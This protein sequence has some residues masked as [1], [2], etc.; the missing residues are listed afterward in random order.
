M[1]IAPT[2]T[3][4][5][6]LALC[7]SLAALGLA[8]CGGGAHAHRHRGA[9]RG[10]GGPLAPARNPDHA[11][12]SVLPDPGRAPGLS[13][14]QIDPGRPTISLTPHSSP[15]LEQALARAR[16]GSVI[17]LASGSYPLLHDEQARTRWVT[18]TGAGDPTPPVI[19]G[20]LLQG[21]QWLRF[22]SVQFG[23]S[24]MLRSRGGHQ[25]GPR[26]YSEHL[27]LYNTTIDCGSDGSLQ[28]GA[29][30]GN[31]G[32]QVRGASQGV[33][34]E[35]VDIHN[36]TTGFA[37]IAQDPVSS[38]ISIT[39]SRI[40]GVSGDDIDLGGLQNVTIDH[41]VIGN[42]RHS[43]PE[44]RWHNDGVQFY[45]NDAHVR[46]TNNVIADSG[47]QLVFIQD[48]VKSRATGSSVNRDVL[49]QNNLIYGASAYAI[50][51]QG[52]EDVR[53]INNTI[54]DNHFGSLLLRRSG[55]TDLAPTDTVVLN[56]IIEGFG[57]NDVTPMID[58]HNIVDGYVNPKIRHAGSGDLY[59]V[60][61]RFVD[62]AQGNFQLADGSPGLG[63]AAPPSV[64]SPHSVPDVDG[65]IAGSPA[66]VTS[67][68][69][70][71]PDTPSRAYAG[72]P[73]ADVQYKT[74]P[75]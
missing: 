30:H 16:P 57:L 61:P 13:P 64:V 75:F 34:L 70:M 41:D 26:H 60:D 4:V 28:G 56:N 37:S 17:H 66:K 49:V 74:N 1:R 14:V 67:I 38:N 21:S 62:A 25:G 45:G 53:F 32:I 55:Y 68:G 18:V 11:G 50:Q 3:S 43:G 44:S 35:G 12:T 5:L 51:D 31:T 59:D 65:F 2:I 39:H 29:R 72:V 9:H 7:L 6:R 27:A 22:V 52:G 24:I 69:A 15:T 19:D 71:Q 73:T 36:C 48:A 58:S 54:W 63:R 47:G 20:A 46:I 42:A 23:S 10:R 40:W 8:A 33:T